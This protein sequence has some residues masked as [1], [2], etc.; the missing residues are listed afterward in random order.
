L[1]VDPDNQPLRTYAQICADLRH[2]NQPTLPVPLSTERAINPFLRSRSRAV[3]NAV[4]QRDARA[5]DDVTTFAALRTW[6]NEF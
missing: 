2:S 6:K 3:S 1:A 4:R 5:M